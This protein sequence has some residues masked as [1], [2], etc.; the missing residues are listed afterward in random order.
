M[1][2]IRGLVVGPPS[3]QNC[4]LPPSKPQVING[5]SKKVGTFEKLTD[6][7]IAVVTEQAANLTRLVAMVDSQESFLACATADG[8]DTALRM[9]QHLVLFWCDLVFLLEEITP[10]LQRLLSAASP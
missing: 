2:V 5:F 3:L 6:S 4:M 8:A 10:T 7:L 9:K 1:N